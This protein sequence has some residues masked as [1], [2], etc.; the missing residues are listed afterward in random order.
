MLLSLDGVDAFGRTCD[1]AVLHVP[2]CLPRVIPLNNHVKSSQSSMEFVLLSS[3]IHEY[4][5][6]VFPGIK[7]TGCHQFRLTRHADLEVDEEE[8]EDLLD[9]LKGELPGRRY[10]KSVRL[11]VANTCPKQHAQFLLDQFAL[12]P[13]DLYRV[14]GP[15]NLN[16]LGTVV[17]LVDRSNLKYSAF[18]PRAFPKN[19]DM[20]ELLQRRD[21][22]LH[23]PFQ[24][25]SP[26][27]DLLQQAAV[28]PDVLAIKQTL[29][30][31][32]KDSP[33]V[34]ALID[35]S[36]AGKEVTAIIELRARFD[37]AANIDIADR[38]QSAGVHIVYGVV[39]YKTH[40]KMMMIVRREGSLLKRYVHLGTGNYHTGTAKTYTDFSLLSADQLMGDDVHYIFQQLTGL[41]ATQ[42]LNKI[43]MAPFFLQ[44]YLKERLA[45]EM[46]EAQAGRRAHVVMKLNSI[47]DPLIITAL[48]EASKAGVQID[49]IVRGIC[50]LKP[51]VLGISE[52]IRV[53]SIAGRF[54][55]HTRIYYFYKAGEEE[56]F[57]ASA[58]LMQRNLYRR[59]EVAFPIENPWLK[60]RVIRE[61]LRVYLEGNIGASTMNA[62]GEYQEAGS[63]LSMLSELE[64]QHDALTSHDVYSLER[65]KL[66]T[67][68][69]RKSKAKKKSNL[70]SWESKINKRIVVQ[71]GQDF[72]AQ[73]WLLQLAD[74]N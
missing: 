51:Q 16:R 36:R 50:C 58:D 1:Y 55:E 63:M 47:N 61:G 18:I 33:F 68:S 17:K 60:V 25:F 39:N 71:E 49:L 9:A 56:V 41:G 69:K 65:E 44:S 19:S 52:N 54:L 64:A 66:Q 72:E 8:V 70:Q 40:A 21:I 10:G 53:R 15:V 34:D 11:E 12:T 74:Q 6:E 57:L 26:V 13:D 4:A 43:K 45:F 73:S 7:V 14:N 22:L 38:L 48:Y 2:R 42:S 67:V 28:D 5:E 31:T 3:V 59:V 32:G 23:H 29:Y 30:R 62:E 20:F 27:V 46:Q 24:S 37:E 35:A